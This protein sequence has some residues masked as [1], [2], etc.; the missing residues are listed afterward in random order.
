[1]R[2]EP[3]PVLEDNVAWVV[4]GHGGRAAVV[5]PGEAG[6]VREALARL[7]AEPA[8]V[9]LTHHHADHTAGASELGVPVYGPTRAAGVTRGLAGGERLGAAEAGVSLEVLHVPGHTRDHLAYAGK[10]FVATGDTLFAAG[11]G[12]LFEGTPAELLASLDRIAALPPETLVLCGHEYT[13]ANLRFAATVE[14]G[15]AA[16]ASRLERTRAL[17]AAGRLAV[18]STLAEELA[19]NPFLRVDVAGV[20]A[21][22]GR[23]AGRPLAARTEVLAVLRAWKDQFPG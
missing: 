10:G 3:V 15:N 16:V 20:R 21:A 19:T 8:A 22:A 18:P 6:P 12:R 9:L 14:P 2:I 17:H 1:V 4:V 7:G 11:C 13:L 5:D 23:R